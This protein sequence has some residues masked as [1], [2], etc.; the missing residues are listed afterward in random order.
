MTSV[1]RARWL[2]ELSCALSE[3]RSLVRELGATE[4]RFEAMELYTQIEALRL[5]VETLR[6][7]R[8]PSEPSFDPDW[9]K[10]PWRGR[11]GTALPKP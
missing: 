9:S 7:R 2:A 1:E 10:S 4:G 5:E 6:I 11:P 8:Q 3:A